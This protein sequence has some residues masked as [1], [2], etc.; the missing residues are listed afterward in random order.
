MGTTWSA[1][2]V[3]ELQRGRGANG[4]GYGRGAAASSEPSAL[5][6]LALAGGAAHADATVAGDA[7]AR[8]QGAGGGVGLSASFAEPK[9]PTALA[10]LAWAALDAHA[11]ERARAV[12]WLLAQEGSR[13]PRSPLEPRG[14]D[15]TIAG[16]PWVEGTHSWVEPTAFALMALRRAHRAE[17]ARFAEGVRLLRD[18]SLPSGGWNMGNTIMFGTE[19]RPQPTPTGL[20]LL[21]LAGAQPPDASIDRACAYLE[22]LLPRTRA[23]MSLAWG[24]LGLTAWSRRPAGADAWLADAFRA[25]ADDGVHLSTALL[26]LAA[27]PDALALFGVTS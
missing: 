11:A 19:L 4:W 6:A 21:A 24:V 26:L 15:T 8:L 12:D 3:E 16:W 23:P 5:A 1:D 17:H 14:H 13:L 20:A 18:R 9:W 27:R 7:L 22:A 2:A 10:V 25:R